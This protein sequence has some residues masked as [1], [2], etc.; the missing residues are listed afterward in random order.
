MSAKELKEKLVFFLKGSFGNSEEYTD[1]TIEAAIY[2]YAEHY[3]AGQHS[4]L[5][6]ILSTSPF[7]PGPLFTVEK[8]EI[9]FSM[10]QALIDEFET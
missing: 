4:D 2:F 8:D 10:Y 6:S 1:S 3:H 7:S 5:Y 9:I